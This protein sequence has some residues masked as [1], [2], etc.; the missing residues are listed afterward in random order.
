MW[1]LLRVAMVLKASLDRVF[2]TAA[3]KAAFFGCLGGVLF[4]VLDYTSRTY[5]IGRSGAYARNGAYHDVE[6]ATVHAVF[7]AFLLG[8]FAVML[9]IISGRRK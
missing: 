8:G 1:L 6:A 4:G 5:E 7:A 2:P 9:F 3:G